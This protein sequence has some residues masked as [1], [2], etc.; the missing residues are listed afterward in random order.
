MGGNVLV[1]DDD[2]VIRFLLRR[3]LEENDCQVL[4]AGSCDEARKVMQ[5]DPPDLVLADIILGSGN[6]IDLVRDIRTRGIDCGIVIITSYPNYRTTR[7]A[8]KLGVFDYLPKPFTKENL[9]EV[10]AAALAQK[11]RRLG[12]KCSQ[13]Y[14][15]GVRGHLKAIVDHVGSDVFSVNDQGAII[16]ASASIKRRC[17]QFKRESGHGGEPHLHHAGFCFK[18]LRQVRS[19]GESTVD[20]QGC[21]ELQADCSTRVN[22]NIS[23]LTTEEDQFYGAV[24]N[25][26]QIG[27]LPPMGRGERQFH[28]MVSID[29]Q[30]QRVFSHIHI[31]KDLDSTV[32]LTGESGT[33]KELVAK[34]LHRAGNR[35]EKPLVKVNCAAFV[36]T[37][38]ESELFGHVKGAFTGAVRD[39]VGCFEQADGGTLFLDEIGDIS[40]L[41]QLRLLRV[42]QEKEFQP[43]GDSR[44]RKVDTRVVAAT[45]RNLPE[46][47]RQGH[48][49]SCIVMT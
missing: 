16:S 46:L 22:V 6:G 45:N 25:C 12:E 7:D 37:L 19:N 5:K 3:A 21:C 49:R 15:R 31:L 30:M 13:Q 4:E 24:L 43:V 9:L 27:V 36:D 20:L 38:L 2:K 1:V 48:F 8:F 29:A 26:N 10:T 47:V 35:R 41:V 40:P 11:R 17:P 44:T 32:L 23:R 39:R 34:A 42:L 14:E 28:G 33:G 18:A